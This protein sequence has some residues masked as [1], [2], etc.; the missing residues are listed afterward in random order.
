MPERPEK[1]ITRRGFMTKFG[2]GPVVANVAGTLLRQALAQQPLAV[3]D[4]PGN[5]LGWA[6]VGLGNLAIPEILPAFAR[7]EKSK[8][9]RAVPMRSILIDRVSTLA[10]DS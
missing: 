4:P 1:E 6:V 9:G 3:P 8:R 5:K 10:V 7:C 2:Q